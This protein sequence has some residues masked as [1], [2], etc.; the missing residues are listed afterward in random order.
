MR[1]LVVSAHLDDAVLSA[2]SVLAEATVV[3]VLAAVPPPGRV[4][5]WDA[6][7]GADDSAARVLERREEDRRAL[8]RAGATPLHLDFADGQYVRA[9]MLPAPVPAEI[10][11][12][13]EELAARAA[14][15]YAPAGIGNPE[16]ALVRD[17]VV[18]AR[19]DAVL[20]ADLPYALRHGWEPDGRDVTLD[21][22]LLAQKLAA[23]RE[24]ATQ[25]RQLER[26]FGDFLC[27]G[28]L[29]RERFWG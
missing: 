28:G 20:Y 18:A 10:G 11:A 6:E 17:A 24:Y 22:D 21:G 4:A 8:A 12:A 16:H 27:A 26:D 7:G 15:V 2:Y 13:L 3:T 25:L 23:V 5:G 1:R 14:E 29:G 9:G 19:P